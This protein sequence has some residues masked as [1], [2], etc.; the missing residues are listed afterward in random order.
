M[1]KVSILISLLLLAPVGF[2]GEIAKQTDAKAQ[3]KQASVLQHSK[4]GLKGEDKR[5]HL[6]EVAEAYAAVPRLF[7]DSVAECTEASFR[8]GEVRRSLGDRDA[9]FLAFE[10]AVELKGNR[11][12]AA[13]ALLE[14]A[15]LQRKAKKIADAAGTYEKVAKD[16]SDQADQRDTAL[17]WAG[18]MKLANKEVDAARASWSIVAEKSQ[19]PFDQIRA[20]D[21]IASS[22]L[23]E[24][25][26]AEATQAVEKCRQLVGPLAEESSS[27]GTR[28]KRALEK[29]KSAAKLATPVASADHEGDADDDED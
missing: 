29:M 8:L 19:D 11:K 15:N 25:K 7:P 10:K 18:K 17:L 1:K 4:K 6:K 5:N 2:A 12:F 26:Q 21:L 13:R 20:F 28:I 16:F 3:L 9:A 23:S 14:M 24:G 27:K 22:Y